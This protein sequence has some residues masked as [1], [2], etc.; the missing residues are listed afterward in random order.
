MIKGGETDCCWALEAK[1]KS[2]NLETESQIK[3]QTDSTLQNAYTLTRTHAYM[4]YVRMH[5]RIPGSVKLFGAL[6]SWFTANQ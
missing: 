2:S 3:W 4:K 6:F 1:S 5:A